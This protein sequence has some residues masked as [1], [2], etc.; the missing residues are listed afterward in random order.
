MAAAHQ[1]VPLVAAVVVGVIAAACGGTSTSP[2]SSTPSAASSTTR[3]FVSVLPFRMF[4]QD[5]ADAVA[6]AFSSK[7]GI[8]I[9]NPVP[10]NWTSSNPAIAT[11]TA[12]GKVTA[13]APGTAQITGSY[14]GM[15]GSVVVTVVAESDL[16][17]L[18][19][20]CPATIFVGQTSFCF[21]SARFRSGE[22]TGV[23]PAW[24]STDP[25]IL[26]FGQLGSITG[27]S[28][29]SVTVAATYHGQSASTPIQVRAEDVLVVDAAAEQGPFTPGS[30]T[31]LW[32]QGFYGVASADS[33]VLTLRI[34]DQSGVAVSTSSKTVSRG[35][36]SFLISSSFVVPSG[37]TQ[38]C[39]TALLQVG[40][41]T[42][43]ATI[44]DAR[45]SC[46]AVAR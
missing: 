31:T 41:K 38:L 35:G 6:Q 36:D 39:R 14:Q 16:V 23:A 27:R 30:T 33:G 13:I 25:A 4:P 46:L 8:E 18:D 20:S 32:L 26:N 28:A 17:A 44:S 11:V 19:L 15:T 42:L 21:A 37:S 43:T 10:A 2:S 7:D 12:A 5:T 34:S 24:S 3:L 29:G 22:V 40:S 9:S 45:L 1:R